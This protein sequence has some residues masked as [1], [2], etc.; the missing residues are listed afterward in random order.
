MTDPDTLASRWSCPG[1][2]DTVATQTVRPVYEFAAAFQIQ[3]WSFTPVKFYP[4]TGFHPEAEPLALL[5]ELMLPCP[6]GAP[7]ILWIDRHFRLRCRNT[8]RNRSRHS[9]SLPVATVVPGIPDLHFSSYCRFTGCLQSLSSESDFNTDSR[10]AAASVFPRQR[11]RCPV[12]SS[13][14]SS[15]APA[16][17]HATVHFQQFHRRNR[18]Q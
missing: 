18:Q 11:T 3:R 14:A 12:C 2:Q 13:A 16:M 4:K 9:F 1:I 7:P 5:N 15:P 8:E 6:V 17:N 10:N